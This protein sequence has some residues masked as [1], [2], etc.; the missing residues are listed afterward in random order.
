LVFSLLNYKDD[1]RSHK[2]KNLITFGKFTVFLSSDY[3]AEKKNTF[4]LR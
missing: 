3:Y 1:A 4:I 2:H